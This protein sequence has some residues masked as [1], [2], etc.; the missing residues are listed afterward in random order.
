[1][2]EQIFDEADEP[3]RSASREGNDLPPDIFE[4]TEKF[5]RRV[6]VTLEK[7]LYFAKERQ[8]KRKSIYNLHSKGQQLK[9]VSVTAR[10]SDLQILRLFALCAVLSLA[11]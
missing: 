2:I 11:N 8:A 5:G 4:N 7:R 1:M 9:D 6:R 3:S 10:I